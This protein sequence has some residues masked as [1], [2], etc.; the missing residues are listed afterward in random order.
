[1]P[2]YEVIYPDEKIIAIGAEIN[3]ALAD[4]GQSIGLADTLIAATAI[5]RG[6]TLVN[7]NTKHFPRVQAAG[8]KITLENWRDS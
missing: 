8:F 5:S 3:A 7:A 6:F 4:A 1:M 2:A